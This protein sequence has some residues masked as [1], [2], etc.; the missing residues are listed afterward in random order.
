MNPTRKSLLEQMNVH[1]IEIIKRKE[2]LGFTQRHADALSECGTFVRHEI[3]FLVDQFYEKQTNIDEIALI[4]GDAGTLA[5]LKMAMER[6]ISDLFSG[7]YDEEY[8]N[9][10]LRIGLVHKRIGVSPKYYLSAMHLLRNLLCEVI[11]SNVS[12]KDKADFA[13]HALDKL[14][15]FDNQFVFDTYIR[16]MLAEIESARNDALAHAK[17]LEEKILERT[18]ELEEFSRRDPL[19]GLYNQ[20]H[21]VEAV[22]KELLNGQRNQTPLCLMYFDLDGFKS[23]NDTMGHL[24]GDDVLRRVASIVHGSVRDGDICCRYG[25]DEFCALLIGCDMQLATHCAERII[26]EMAADGLNVSLSIGIA[27][28]GCEHWPGVNEL[29]GMADRLMYQSKAHSRGGYLSA[30][31]AAQ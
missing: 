11:E 5:R 22:K 9:N 27:Q 12:P 10:R 6:Y 28:A 8:V 1:D 23:V 13:I 18:F 17:N 31:W 15:N 3:N 7:L 19:T 16:S 24:A 4:I 20:R 30:V 14:M 2:L 29:I 26:R 25:G 21:F